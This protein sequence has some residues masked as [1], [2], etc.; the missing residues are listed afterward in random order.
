MGRNYI[1]SKPLCCL[2]N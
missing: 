1:N 2:T